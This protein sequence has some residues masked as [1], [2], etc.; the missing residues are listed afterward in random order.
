MRISP[1]IGSV[2]PRWALTSSSAMM[3]PLPPG[4]GTAFARV[5]R[6]LFS[7]QALRGLPTLLR[8]GVVRGPTVSCG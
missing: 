5:V 3:D 1:S 4:S 7:A 6:Y 8:L 2:P